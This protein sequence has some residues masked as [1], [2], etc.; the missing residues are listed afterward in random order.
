MRQDREDPDR[1]L[2]CAARNGDRAAF[3]EIVRRHKTSTYQ[4]VR[5]YVGDADEAYDILQDTFVAA[6]QG[7]HRFDVR[8]ELTPWLRTIAL[9]KC[10]DHARRHAVRR[11]LLALFH[12]QSAAEPLWSAQAS[13]PEL[14]SP[15][16]ARLRRL[17]QAIAELPRRYKEPLLLVLVSGLTHRQAAAQLG[18]TPKAVEMRIRR[19]KESLRAALAPERQGIPDE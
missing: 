2:A 7:M 1:P 14:G 6:W 12:A 15:E 4:F 5:R 3:S 16:L 18:L 11:R 8:Q 10:R 13:Y 17:D 19:A 9:N